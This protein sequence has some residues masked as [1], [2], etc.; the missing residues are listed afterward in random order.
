MPVVGGDTTA[1]PVVYDQRDGARAERARPGRAGARAGGDDRLHRGPRRCGAAFRDGRYSVHRCA[2]TRGAS[3]RPPR[4]RRWTSRTAWGPRPHRA[5]RACAVSSSSSASRSPAGR[6]WPTSV[7]AR[8]SAR[9]GRAGSRAVSRRSDGSRRGRASSYCSTATRTRSAAGSARAGT[10]PTLSRSVSSAGRLAR[11]P[12]AHRPRT[13]SRSAARD[14]VARRGRRIGVD[15]DLHD[16]ER[17]LLEG[18]LDRLARPAPRRQKSTTTGCSAASTSSANVASVTSRM[19]PIIA[20]MAMLPRN[21]VLA[22]QF[23][24]LADLMELEGADS[25]RI[26]AYEGLG[27]DPRD[28][29]V[30]R[31]AALDGKAKL[32]QG[33]GKTIEAKIVE[34]VDDGETRAD[35]AKG[36]SARRRSRPSCGCPGSARRRRG[37]SGRSSGSRPW[38]G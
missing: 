21:D 13:G 25:F 24:L 18:R 33:I 6:Q 30:G 4:T 17:Q 36:G 32:L 5:A 34:V 26:G 20:T 15:V 16:V 7:S 28:A 10:Q 1:S 22:E 2:S 38:T 11:S 37:G 23:D 9:R 12:A 8:T 35:E 31:A 3:S 29:V 14:P 19:P 27:A